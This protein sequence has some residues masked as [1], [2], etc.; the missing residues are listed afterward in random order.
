MVDFSQDEAHRLGR[1]CQ[2]SSGWAAD[3]HEF[4]HSA[5]RSLLSNPSMER[6]RAIAELEHLAKHGHAPASGLATAQHFDRATRRCRIRV[7]AVVDDDNAAAEADDLAAVM[8][9]LQRGRTLRHR[10]QRHVEM[11][12]DGCRGEDV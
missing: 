9:R 11:D 8:R 4:I 1:F 6:D 10:R 12:A 5:G 2:L 7:V 3:G